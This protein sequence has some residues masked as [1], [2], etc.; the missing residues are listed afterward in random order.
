MGQAVSRSVKAKKQFQLPRTSSGLKSSMPAQ[1]QTRE[2]MLSEDPATAQERDSE[3]TKVSDNLKY[4]LNPK[5]LL[6]PITPTNPRENT[7]V[8]ALL[9]RREDDD[10]EVSGVTNR[11]SAQ[12]I[13]KALLEYGSGSG[14]TAALAGKSSIDKQVLRRTP[15]TGA[16]G[17]SSSSAAASKR[18]S[19][20]GTPRKM[21]SR[22]ESANASGD[23]FDDTE[24]NASDDTW[25]VMGDDDSKAIETGD[26]WQEIFDE[27]LD[28]LGEKRAATREKALATVVRIMSLRYLG[29]ELAGSR[30]M[31]LEALKKSAKSHKSDKESMLALLAIG[32]WFINFGMEESDEYAATETMLKAIVSDHKT[33]SVRAIALNALGI[34]NFIAGVDFNDA[35]DIMKFISEKFFTTSATAPIALLH[36]AFETYGFLLTVVIDGNLQLA[37]NTFDKVF[38]AHLDALAVD[39]VDVRVAAAQ[40]FALMH[41]ALSKGTLGFEFEFDRQDELVAT[42]QAI[43]QESAKRHGKRDTQAQRSA[44]R[45]VLKTIDS[46]EAPEM[47]LV[48]GG[49]SVS[50]DCWARIVRL[51][52]F[53]ACL[54]G[55]LPRHFVENPLLQ[56]IFEVEF[57]MS[58][59]AFSRNEGRVVINPSSEIAKM[60]SKEMR[61][62][63]VVQNAYLQQLDYDYE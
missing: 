48:L 38:K 63:R 46:G 9:H 13:R 36:Q 56:D 4:F 54:G 33:G 19:R 32:L 43:R 24:S 53:R 60:R 6:T 35:V 2:Q 26:S 39:T 27:A 1:P 12:D 23:E 40:N 21:Q 7:N 57:D 58:S 14:N 28:S 42:L 20:Q 22:T 52:S 3:D 45:D 30:I 8:Q 10:I 18:G 61:K 5:E 34:A 11:L 25:V 31:L 51:H 59:D 41:E 17:R 47:R 55:G 44:M 37:E 16:G 62:R 50:F 49:R 15:S 29:E